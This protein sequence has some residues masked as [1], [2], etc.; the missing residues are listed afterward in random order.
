M[1]NPAR[2]ASLPAERFSARKRGFTLVEL[3]VVITIIGILIALLLPAVQAA[4]EA[5]RR[6]QC[7]N[8]LKQIGLALHSYHDA[9]KVLPGG[10]LYDTYKGTVPGNTWCTAIMPY[11]DLRGLYDEL[12]FSHLFGNTNVNLNR[13][14]IAAENTVV[15]AFACPSDPLSAKPILTD[16]WVAAGQGNENGSTMNGNPQT[17]M[18][19]WYPASTGPTDDQYCWNCT[20]GHTPSPTN[21]CCQGQNFGIW[22]TLAGYVGMFG[23]CPRG[24]AF[25]DVK[26]GLSNTIMCGETLPGE[27]P[28]V[29]VYAG[30]FTVM[31]THIPIDTL[32]ADMPGV[33]SMDWYRASGF[34]S[35]HPGMVNFLLADGSV[36]SLSRFVDYDLV[37]ALG[38]RAGGEIAQAP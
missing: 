27:S 24:V 10:S 7:S 4:R 26:D 14:N 28:F 13:R 8:N 20:V 9:N 6:M 34:K 12:D 31:A 33:T 37:N 36:R 19:L 35:L 21:K 23:R 38:T 1:V 29:S 30:N 2:R 17:A 11:L 32:L 22:N 3:L 25:S 15:P 18:G 16:R 5:A